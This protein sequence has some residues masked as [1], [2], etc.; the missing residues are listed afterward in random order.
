VRIT[1]EGSGYANGDCQC[2][3]FPEEEFN[4]R[5][6]DMGENVLPGAWSPFNNSDPKLRDTGERFREYPLQRAGL[7]A[8]LIDSPSGDP[9]LY[10]D[11]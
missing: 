9:E 11:E 5:A 6:F 2:F 10:E 1:E 8:T 3:R 7:V 4:L